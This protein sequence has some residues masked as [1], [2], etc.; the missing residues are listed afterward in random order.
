MRMDEIPIYVG[1]VALAVM[2]FDRRLKFHAAWLWC[3]V[4]LAVAGLF[5]PHA[6]ARLG[7]ENYNLVE[8]LRQD[9]VL[10]GVRIAALC[11][12]APITASCSVAMW[13]SGSRLLAACWAPAGCLVAWGM[14]RRAVT[15]ESIQDI[16][17]APV[18]HW[19]ADLEYIARMSAV[20]ISFV[21]LP[22]FFALAS[23]H[24]R[25]WLAA[26]VAYSVALVAMSGAIVSGYTPS[27]NVPELFRAHGHPWFVSACLLA[28]WS[29]VLCGT[30]Y[31]AA[32]W[33]A[34]SGAMVLSS[35]LAGIMLDQALLLGEIHGLQ[36]G[37]ASA[38]AA[39]AAAAMCLLPV[40]TTT[41]PRHGGSRT[42]TSAPA[43]LTIG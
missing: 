8:M 33:L 25:R 2:V 37:P 3:A 19:P 43:P 24:S 38:A 11:L 10:P 39:F 1:L 21:W 29:A 23:R 34:A 41:C 26:A 40:A 22:I 4:P 17:G 32:G 16:L 35:A 7:G 13:M 5:L 27:D 36:A 14:L 15:V 9:R 20:Y 28:P 31:R 6:L 12:L 18:L 42:L 30:A